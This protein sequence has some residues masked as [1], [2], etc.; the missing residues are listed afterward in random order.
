MIAILHTVQL[1]LIAKA[2]IADD[3]TPCQT[4]SSFDADER[5]KPRHAPRKAGMLGRRH[6]RAHVLVG[7]RRLFGDAA[8]RRAP[9]Q[10]A[11]RCKV[12]DDLAP[13]PLLE[14]GMAGHRTAGAV[15]R[16]RESLFLAGCL[17]HEN[18]RA[19]P[20]AAADKHRLA[21]GTQRLGQAFMT[22]PEGPGRAFAMN[23]Q[24]APLS[25]DRMCA[26]TLQVL[27]ETSNSRRRSRLGKK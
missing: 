27:C 18:V 24:L 25:V 22:G 21:D 17:A 4:R 19:R 20:H 5:P 2:S 3:P 12:I 10:D 26:S 6:D 13:A 9:D 7:A 23:E 16:G 1:R 15:A 8:G 11:L 14:R